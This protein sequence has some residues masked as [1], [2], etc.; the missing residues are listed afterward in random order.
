MVN[1]IF[2][3][4]GISELKCCGVN[5][6]EL[7][8]MASSWNG[9][10]QPR[11]AGDIHPSIFN[12]LYPVLGQVG[13][14]AYPS[15]HQAKGRL[16]AE[17]VV[18]QS[19]GTHRNN[20]PFTLTFTLSLRVT[21]THTTCTHVSW[22]SAPPHHRWPQKETN[23]LPIGNFIGEMTEPKMSWII[24]TVWSKND[25][26]W[27]K[28]VK[29]GGNYWKHLL[30]F[31]NVLWT[32]VKFTVKCFVLRTWKIL[33]RMFWMSFIHPSIFHRWMALRV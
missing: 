17:V 16:H 9:L 13:A 30:H 15:W 21:W 29:G 11:N 27:S 1:A 23:M 28:H 3:E 31:G 32:L 33:P 4:I 10:N 6:I 20:Q 18:S 5:W 8:N 12:I 25:L 22:P 24:Q 2:V 7:L 14:G 26:N 19:Q